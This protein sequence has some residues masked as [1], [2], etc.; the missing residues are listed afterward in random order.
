MG[1]QN[2]KL[3]PTKFS[4]LRT[5]V[6]FTENELQEWHNKFTKDFPEGSVTRD[7]FRRMYETCFPDG[8]AV[9]FT[10]HVFEI[11]DTN[12][13]GKVDFKEF[14]TVVSKVFSE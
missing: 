7:E 8:E 13:D 10:E 2:S 12:G 3:K 4:D 11:Y 5:E 9:K 6:L 1:K 14:M